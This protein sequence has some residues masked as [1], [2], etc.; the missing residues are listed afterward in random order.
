MWKCQILPLLIR[1]AVLKVLRFWVLLL[2]QKIRNTMILSV[3]FV[4]CVFV[5]GFFVLQNNI[6]T[7]WRVG[8]LK[9]DIL[10]ISSAIFL[11]LTIISSQLRPG[12]AGKK[13]ELIRSS[14]IHV[15]NIE[16]SRRSAFDSL[17]CFCLV[18]KMMPP[19]CHVATPWRSKERFKV[20]TSHHLEENKEQKWQK[21][22]V[23]I[24]SWVK[25]E[26]NRRVNKN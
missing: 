23:P 17:H 1:V 9:H 8:G 6:C 16:Q 7:I 3:T 22:V 24:V 4:G 25:T 13:W 21:S 20:P 5:L 2:I 18:M 10:F 19:Q 26:K 11:F 12:D 15:I 14:R